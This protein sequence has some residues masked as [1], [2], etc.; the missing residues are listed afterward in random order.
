MK[1]LTLAAGVAALI[2]PLAGANSAVFSVGGPL[3][4][5]CY[6]AALT[7]DDRASELQGCSRALDE[8]ALTSVER[9][10]TLVN[11]GIIEMARNQDLAADA[12]FDAALTLNPNLPDAWLNKGFLRIRKGDGRDALPFLQQ[13]IERKPDRQALAI[14]ARGVAYEEMG[15]YRSAYADLTRAHQLEPRWS[16]PSEYLSHYRVISQ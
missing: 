11:R 12:D 3:S 5:L 9:A 1:S 15:Q 10:A 4:L 14:F 2:L 13:G 7:Q 6:K 8:E 16:L